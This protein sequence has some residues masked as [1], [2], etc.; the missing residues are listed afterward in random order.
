M[1]GGGPGQGDLGEVHHHDVRARGLQ[2]LGG[3]RTHAGG[4]TDDQ[5]PLAVEAE[6][7]KQGH[8]KFLRVDVVGIRRRRRGP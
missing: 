7:V 5:R 4:A 3:G 8:V 6:C 2:E 1:D